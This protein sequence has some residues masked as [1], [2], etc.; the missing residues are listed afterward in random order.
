M[1]FTLIWLIFQSDEPNHAMAYFLFAVGIVCP[2]LGEAYA[3]RRRQ[4]DWYRRRFASFDELR[5]SVNASALRQIREEKGLWDAI[6][7]LK[8]EYPLLPVG[9]AAKLIKGL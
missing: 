3:V 6:H 2:G 1:S 9:E 7:E 5:M 4:R 8:R